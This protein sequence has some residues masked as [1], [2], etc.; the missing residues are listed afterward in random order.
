MPVC[1]YAIYIYIYIYIY[2]I[3]AYIHTH[4]HSYAQQVSNICKMCPNAVSVERCIYIHT[5]IHT[6]THALNRSAAY[7]RCGQMQ[8]ALN[9]AQKCINMKPE[10]GKGYAMKAVALRGLNK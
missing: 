8:S 10:W 7:A 9:D 3:H 5:C 6:Y 2:I 1:V 4:I